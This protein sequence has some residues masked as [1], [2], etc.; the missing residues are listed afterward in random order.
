MLRFTGAAASV[1]HDEKQ[2]PRRALTPTIR[3]AHFEKVERQRPEVAARVDCG[4][5]GK[6]Q[7]Y[8][9]RLSGRS[10]GVLL[11]LLK[12]FALLWS[13]PPHFYARQLRCRHCA[14]A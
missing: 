7:A 3:A 9:R 10:M 8:R 14:A 1:R 11:R 2:I 13:P 6:S 4:A 5:S 12:D